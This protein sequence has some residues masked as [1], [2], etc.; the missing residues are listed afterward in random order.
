MTDGAKASVWNAVWQPWGAP[1]SIT[2]TATLDARFPGQW[3]Q[4]EAG[5]HYNWHRHYDP[6][7]GRYTQP[8]PLGFV[9]GPSVY[10]YAGSAPY[11][12]VDRDGRY[13][14]PFGQIFLLGLVWLTLPDP[15]PL[16]TPPAPEPPRRKRGQQDPI[17][18]VPV[19]PGRDCKGNCNPCP[20]NQYWI[21]EEPGHG[22][23]RHEHG[24]EWNQNKKSCTCY[25]KRISRKL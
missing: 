19:D 18:E 13:A 25:P 8:D 6:S 3:Y 21:V 14:Y 17:I 4:L 11:S 23:E 10:A 7:L 9:D 15:P 2:G 22:G 20:P 24:I 1:Q 5:L 12:W 16:P